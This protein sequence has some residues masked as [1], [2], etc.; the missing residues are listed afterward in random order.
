MVL[1]LDFG[2]KAILLCFFFFLIIDLYLLIPAVIAQIFNPIAKIVIP[3]GVPTKEAKAEIDTHPVIVNYNNW[4]IN[5][6]QNSTNFFM[7]LTH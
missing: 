4:A 7:L 5:I 2:S 3:I 1:N 6:I